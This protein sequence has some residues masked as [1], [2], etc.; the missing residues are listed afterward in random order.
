MS[1]SVY[2][3]A[4]SI[5]R[6]SDSKRGSI[7]S[8]V[9]NS[10]ST[11]KKR[12]YAL[13][14]KTLKERNLLQA[15]VDESKLIIVEPK[16]TPTLALVLLHDFLF[17]KG[18][19][20]GGP[21]KRM[22]HKHKVI[23]RQAYLRLSSEESLE[24]VTSPIQ[25]GNSLPRYVR[26]NPLKISEENA[27]V[28]LQELGYSN[29]DP[30]SSSGADT[31]SCNTF[32]KDS[33]LPHI[34]VFPSGTDLTMTDLYQEGAIF[35]QDKASCIPAFVLDPPP[36]SSVIDA[37][38][39]PGNKTTHLAGIMANT[40]HI[41]A[42]DRDAKR[43]D[44]L[45]NMVRKAGAKC[46]TTQLADFLEVN[47]SDHNGVEYILLDPS[48]SGSGI[49]NRDDHLTAGDTTK[50]SV[51]KRLKSLSAFQY[52][53]LCHALK[54]PNVKR[55]VYSTCS[56]YPEENELVVQ[57]ALQKNKNF[58]LVGFMPQWKQRG[59]PIFEEACLCLRASPEE[60]NTTGF[61]VAKLERS[62]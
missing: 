51:K 50:E 30:T 53:I 60:N 41:L 16:L 29:E 19:C 11:Q 23:L 47:P 8:L 6:K 18:I 17:G 46:V 22:I 38:A 3:L 62:K 48:C 32:H 12:L 28:K 36:G 33:D 43:F 26:I 15:V 55:V 24:T 31:T 58:K 57:A 25:D 34:L 54:F 42:F 59:L 10:N 1:A 7:K 35:L 2:K 37:C 4:A 21:L 13:V 40:G 14:C 52:K 49:I 27:I 5:I 39:A 45:R 56:V 9:F 44:T 61:F 20:C